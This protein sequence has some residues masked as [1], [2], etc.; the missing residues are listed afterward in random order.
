MN[1]DG[2]GHW[3]DT[4]RAAGWTGRALRA[5]PGGVEDSVDGRPAGQPADGSAGRRRPASGGGET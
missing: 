4:S 5:A 3:G 1:R 2:F